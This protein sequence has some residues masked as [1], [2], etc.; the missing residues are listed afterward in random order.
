[1]RIL[2][3]NFIQ[4]HPRK[5]DDATSQL[6]KYKEIPVKH[7]V[8]TYTGKE[9]VFVGYKNNYIIYA[10][11][12]SLDGVPLDPY[13][14][15]GDMLL[16]REITDESLKLLLERQAEV[17]Q[18]VSLAMEE[19]ILRRNSEIHFD[20]F[21]FGP[22]RGMMVTLKDKCD[23]FSSSC[24]FDLDKAKKSALWLS[25]HLD[26]DAIEDW[27]NRYRIAIKTTEDFGQAF[28]KEGAIFASLD[29]I[30]LSENPRVKELYYKFLRCE[31]DSYHAYMCDMCY[32]NNGH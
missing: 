5:T 8:Y 11:E 13:F 9:L 24:L 18:Y 22:V 17:T 23:E 26:W 28:H 7:S 3:D 12:M 1:M 4:Y 29:F 30:S 20:K 27:I 25:K 10:V 31:Q 32:R 2:T 15:L 14:G 21:H 6:D 19:N 16:G